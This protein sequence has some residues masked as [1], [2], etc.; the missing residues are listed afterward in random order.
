[1]INS[2]F[3]QFVVF[4]TLSLAYNQEPDNWP[5]NH[6]QKKHT[7][8]MGKVDSKTK[9]AMV[10]FSE[11]EVYQRN[12]WDREDV[13]KVD[14]LWGKL[15]DRIKVGCQTYNEKD[16]TKISGDT[17]INVRKVDKA[18]TLLNTT[19]CFNSR[20]CWHNFTL[21]EPIF[22]IC[23]GKYPFEHRTWARKIGDK[24]Q[25]SRFRILYYAR[26]AGLPL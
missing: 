23:L 11:N 12:Q 20:E 14:R 13:H 10:F 16:N 1:M 15:G 17:L 8:I 7:G 22:I 5:W 4:C 26:T 18:F 9:L 6:A 2:G 21:T 24:W 19:M 3:K 25:T